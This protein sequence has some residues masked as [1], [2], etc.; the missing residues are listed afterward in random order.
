MP[1]IFY[2][3]IDPNFNLHENFSKSIPPSPRDE[4]RRGGEADTKEEAEEPEAEESE[5]PSRR[6]ISGS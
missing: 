5:E 3:S 1:K 4:R 2:T 6:T